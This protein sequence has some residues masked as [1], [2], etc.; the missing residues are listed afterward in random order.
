VWAVHPDEGLTYR[1]GLRFEEL[2]L[3][4]WEE[5]ARGAHLLHAPP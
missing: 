4:V 3:P 5:V 1:G 2:C